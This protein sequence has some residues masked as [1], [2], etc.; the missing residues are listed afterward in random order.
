M[1][2]E[3]TLGPVRGQQCKGVYD[4][5][6]YS[7]ESIPFAEVPV[8][9]LRFRSPQPKKPWLEILDCTQKPNK[10]VQKN[11]FNNQIEGSE[12][13]LYVNIFV[14]KVCANFTMGE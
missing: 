7:F 5:V 1:V 13:C 2:I 10:P 12:D 3:T 8:G 9:E 14:K 11:P 4:D 6:Y